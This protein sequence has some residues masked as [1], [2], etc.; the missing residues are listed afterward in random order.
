M[1][2]AYEVPATWA[3]VGRLLLEPDGD[4]IPPREPSSWYYAP[5]L[6]ELI[7]SAEVMHEI[8]TH[9]FSHTYADD[10]AVSVDV[11]REDLEAACRISGEYGLALRSIVYPRNQVRY[12]ELLPDYGIIAYRGVERNWYQNRRGALH[13]VDRA[14]GLPATTYGL[15]DLKVSDRLVNLPSSQFLLAY[16]GVRQM[17]PT[18]SRVRQACLG[19]RRAARLGEVY[20]L[21]F[22]PFNLGTSPRMFDALERIL[23]E[24]CRRRDSGDLSV[25]TMGDAA[26]LVLRQESAGA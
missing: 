21:W 16:D 3:V 19:L 4:R 24:V 20:H 18:A 26:E 6:P 23:R 5:Y 8:G 22:H 11:W 1:L 25:L 9:T 2:D 14:L 10:P 17:I 15:A 13:F 7:G 12:T